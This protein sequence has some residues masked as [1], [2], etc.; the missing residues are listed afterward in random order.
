[1]MLMGVSPTGSDGDMYGFVDDRPNNDF[2]Q[3]NP[4]VLHNTLSRRHRL[5]PVP[6][7][8]Y[9][10]YCTNSNFAPH[11]HLARYN[12]ECDPDR[13]ATAQDFRDTRHCTNNKP[14]QYNPAGWYNIEYRQH[15]SER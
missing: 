6:A 10:H 8:C 15:T 14:G 11:N 1:M 5:V 9:K 4:A 2:D 12:I 13:Q 3:Y 7:P